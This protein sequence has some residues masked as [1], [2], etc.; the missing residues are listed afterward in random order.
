MDDQGLEVLLALAKEYPKGFRDLLMR[1]FEVE[2]LFEADDQRELAQ[3]RVSDLVSAYASE[4][5]SAEPR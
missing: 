4:H 3:Q 5:A 1:V 2:R